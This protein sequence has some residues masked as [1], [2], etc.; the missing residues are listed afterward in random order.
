V[1]AIGIGTTWRANAKGEPL[2]APVVAWAKRAGWWLNARLPRRWRRTRQATIHAASGAAS[3]TTSVE[4]FA[5][6]WSPLPH[7]LTT[8][9]AIAELESRIRKVAT[10]Y[11]TADHQIQRDMRGLE[12]QDEELGKRVDQIQ[13][14]VA[15]TARL[16]RVEGLRGQA[17]G[18]G[19]IAAGLVLQT[20]GPLRAQ[21]CVRRARSCRDECGG[22]APDIVRCGRWPGSP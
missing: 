6:G 19:L 22:N 18:I 2:T 12:R 10:D 1:T 3:A 7:D 8:E 9:E 21:D 11:Q 17:V 20:V 5:T 13:V 15:E 16:L 14:Q 4:G